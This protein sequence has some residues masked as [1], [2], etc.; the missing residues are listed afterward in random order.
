M[1]EHRHRGGVCRR[2]WVTLG[3]NVPG[4]VPWRLLVPLLLA[5][6]LLGV[7]A[8]TASATGLVFS[9]GFESGNTQT[10]DDRTP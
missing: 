9:D 1:A 3:R 2:A 5:A 7:I 6:L 8:S 4:R 10:W